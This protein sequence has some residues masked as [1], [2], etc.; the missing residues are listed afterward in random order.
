[1]NEEWEKG[2]EEPE[3]TIRLIFVN[4]YDFNPDGPTC[5]KRHVNKNLCEIG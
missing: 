3:E 5:M 4:T 1:M 2:G